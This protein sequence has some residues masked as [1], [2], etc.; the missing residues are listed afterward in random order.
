[1]K[2]NDPRSFYER[3]TDVLP[4]FEKAL[5][6]LGRRI[7]S[8]FNS[9]FGRWD[10]MVE[11]EMA[12][13]PDMVIDVTIYAEEDYYADTVTVWGNIEVFNQFMESDNV[14]FEAPRRTAS[15]GPDARVIVESVGKELLAALD[16]PKESADD[17]TSPTL[18]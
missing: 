7:D 18:I 2:T 10:Y 1:M 15:S 8:R 3:E 13:L 11:I 14:V 17:D 6:R 9:D 12:A 4:A 16:V 5:E